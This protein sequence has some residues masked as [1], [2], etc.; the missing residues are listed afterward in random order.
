[1]SNQQF[2]RSHRSHS[3]TTGTPVQT[4][5]AGDLMSQFT[6]IAFT[7]ANTA[8]KL[9]QKGVHLA[10]GVM[11]STADA[12]GLKD[13]VEAAENTVRKLAARGRNDANKAVNKARRM[14]TRAIDFNEDDHFLQCYDYD[15]LLSAPGAVEKR[16]PP[17][18]NHTPTFT[19]PANNALV[20]KIR[21]K[22]WDIGFSIREIPNGDGQPITMEPL[23]RYGADSV[24]SGIITAVTNESRI[25][26]F[27]FDNSHSP[28]QGKNIVYWVAIGE[29]VSLQDD[30]NG[31]VRSKE[32]TAAEEGPLLD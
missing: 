25:I 12:V 9:T 30:Q 28:L 17:L 27:L 31:G 4:S 16:I 19:L 24:I 13:K 23:V 18:G 3:I 21:V 7:A 32:M 1:M 29:N 26:N 10:S 2:G 11:F 22:K 8:T 20:Y 14:A 6:S 15:L 5:A